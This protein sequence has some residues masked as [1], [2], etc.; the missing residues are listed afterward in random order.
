[1]NAQAQNK[2]TTAAREK[3]GKRVAGTYEFNYYKPY[4]PR[5]IRRKILQKQMTKRN[6]N[7]V[8]N[9]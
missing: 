6:I 4:I 3:L 2:V 7:D 8:L 5:R 9:N 1:M